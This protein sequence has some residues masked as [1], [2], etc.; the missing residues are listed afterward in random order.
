MSEGNSVSVKQSAAPAGDGTDAAA[1]AGKT[2]F[3]IAA[4][5]VSSAEGPRY[6]TG[7]YFKRESC[8]SI[9]VV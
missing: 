2:F 8:E 3:E 6:P 1:I 4:L 7:K 5:V 9:E